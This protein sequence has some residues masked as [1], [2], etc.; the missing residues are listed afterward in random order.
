MVSSIAYAPRVPLLACPFCREM[1]EHKERGTCPHCDVPLTA[2]EKLPP[3]YEA[4][5][6]DDGIPVAPEHEPL[7]PRDLRRGKGAIAL[8]AF[9]GL[10]LFFL[11]WVDM[12]LPE[13]TTFSGFDLARRLG[14][15]WGAAC[16][17]VV[18]VPTVL[19]RRSIAQLRGARV[20]ATFL[21]AIPAVTVAILLA[22][23][24]HRGLVPVKFVWGWPMYATLLVSCAA[25]VVSL[26]LGG[27][28]DDVA[29]R[30]GSSRGQTLH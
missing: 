4:A 9:A 25:S 29:V 8:L 6:E 23:A 24:P 5:L 7:P 22:R 14:W 30:R 27:P 21:A 12:T 1:F 15:A 17:W 2:F 3:S 28:L 16:A 11:P 13:V 26:R 18:L 19:S 20:I 10:V